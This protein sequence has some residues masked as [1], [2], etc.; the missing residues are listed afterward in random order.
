MSNLKDKRCKPR[1]HDL[2]EYGA[3]LRDVVVFVGPTPPRSMPLAME[4]VARTVSISM[5]ACDPIPTDM[6]LPWWSTITA[7][8]HPVATCWVLKIEL[9]RTP[10]RNIVARTWPND[11]NIMKHSQMLHKK[12]VHLQTWGNNTQHVATFRNK[13]NRICKDWTR[14]IPAA[15]S[16][17]I[18][19]TAD[20]IIL[21]VVGAWAIVSGGSGIVPTCRT[22]GQTTC[23]T[24][25]KTTTGPVSRVE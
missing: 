2:T 23:W 21:S 5:H 24:I 12:F 7:F 13:S 14:I 15:L 1:L 20:F 4:R 9:L 25:P 6:V 19:C 8:G 10:E 22:S 3:M 16:I 17:V 18:N 11:Y